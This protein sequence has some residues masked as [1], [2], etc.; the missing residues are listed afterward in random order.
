MTGKTEATMSE[1][2]R[3]MAAQIQDTAQELNRLM[4]RAAEK[5]KVSTEITILEVS[6][7]GGTSVTTFYN[8]T[9]RCF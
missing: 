5:E 4:R 7:I 2:A 3:E 1:A 8:I 9:T 6:Q